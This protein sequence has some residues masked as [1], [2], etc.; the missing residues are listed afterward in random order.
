ML[1]SVLPQGLWPV[2]LTPFCDDGEID[3]G[4]LDALTDWYLAAGAAGL[5]AVC[6]SSEMYALAPGE[7]LALARHIVN[8]VQ[9]RVP[10]IATGTFG[11]TLQPQADSVRRMADTGVQAAVVI[12]SQFASAAEPEARLVE[13][14]SELAQMT[15][16]VALGLYECPAPYKRILSPEAYGQLARSGRFLFHKDTTCDAEAMRHKLAAGQGTPLQ[17]YNANTPTALATLRSGAAGVSCIA[18]NVYPELLVWLCRHWQQRPHEAEH[19][20]RILALLDLVVSTKYPN[21]AKR[22]LQ[23]RGLPIGMMCR[24]G[25]VTF[26]GEDAT[27]HA[28]ALAVIAEIAAELGIPMLQR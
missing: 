7:R 3:Y 26:S 13:R 23:L 16:P 10:V 2:M 8:R 17:L 4:A 18:A 12:T 15:E 1:S 22:M 20:Q 14:V 11:G 21:S 19:L 25:S 24:L 6:L 27:H 28:N 5:F 9:G